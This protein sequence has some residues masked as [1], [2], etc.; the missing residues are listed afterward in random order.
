MVRAY[1]LTTCDILALLCRESSNDDLNER[2]VMKLWNFGGSTACE[3][4]HVSCPGV[5]DMKGYFFVGGRLEFDKLP[6]TTSTSDLEHARLEGSATFATRG[7]VASVKLAQFTGTG[8]S[9]VIVGMRIYMC[10]YMYCTT[11]EYP[12][13]GIETIRTL[14]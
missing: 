6:S 14:I 1:G 3:D 13:E 9:G 10:I 7:H 11:S 8:T 12:V 5:Q 2:G 4:T